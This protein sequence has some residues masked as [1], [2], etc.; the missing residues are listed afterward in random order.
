M[1]SSRRVPSC[2]ANHWHV[3]SS[4]PEGSWR[5]STDEEIFMTK[6]TASLWIWDLKFAFTFTTAKCFTSCRTH[7]PTASGKLSQVLAISSE[8]LGLLVERWPRCFQPLHASC[9]PVAVKPVKRTLEKTARQTDGLR[10][11]KLSE[12]SL[13][14]KVMGPFPGVSETHLDQS[15]FQ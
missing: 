15:F 7:L 4:A 13:Y 9:M 11:G 10:E 12:D 6:I 2:S 5:L 1:I 3:L 14:S 8:I